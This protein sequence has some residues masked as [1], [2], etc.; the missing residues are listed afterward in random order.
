MKVKTDIVGNIPKI[1]NVVVYNPPYYKRIKLVQISDFTKSGC[2]KG[3]SKD[4]EFHIIK[5]NFFITNINL[6]E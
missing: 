5:T 4:G 1:G 2:P 6:N 3:K